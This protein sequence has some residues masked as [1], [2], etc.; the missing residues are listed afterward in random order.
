[1][2]RCISQEL[3]MDWPRSDS[4]STSSTGTTKI[5]LYSDYRNIFIHIKK[6]KINK[7]FFV[8]NG[9]LRLHVLLTFCPGST[10]FDNLFFFKG[11]LNV[12]TSTLDRLAPVSHPVEFVMSCSESV[13]WQPA[14]VSSSVSFKSSLAELFLF[15]DLSN[16]LFFPSPKHE[17]SHQIL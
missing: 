5:T 2:A 1:M 3:D 12:T 6:Q 13:S 17:K 11:S 10:A 7:M 14:S 9:L 8:D 15:R 4:G 16:L